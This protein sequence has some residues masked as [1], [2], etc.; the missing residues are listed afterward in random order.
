MAVINYS[1][2]SDSRTAAVCSKI[3]NEREGQSLIVASNMNRARRLAS[4]L[5]FFVKKKIYLLESEDE[6]L[7]FYE[8]KNREPLQQR[9]NAMK[10]LSTGEDCV[11]VA[12]VFSAVKKLM[13]K[14]EFIKNS[15]TLE[16]NSEMDIKE[17]ATKLVA[18]GYERVSLV[19]GKGQFSIRGSILDIYLPYEENPTR[20]EFFDIE[21]ESIRVFD[22]DTQRSLGKLSKIHIYPAVA[23]AIEDEHIKKAVAQVE[24][25]YEH[26]PQRLGELVEQIEQK[27]N[28]QHLEYYIDYFFEKTETI[29][30]YLDQQVV[31]IDDPTRCMEAIE[32]RKAEYD[33]D[34][35]ELLNRG[36]VS[37]FDYGNFPGPEEYKELYKKE[38]VILC[39]PFS[40]KIDGVEKYDDLKEMKILEPLDFNGQMDVLVRE[41]RKYLQREYK[42]VIAVSTE[43]RYESLK[44]L[45][46][47][48]KITKGITLHRGTLSRGM[49][50]V[51]QQILLLSDKDIFGTQKKTKR[52][53]RKFKNAK[54]IKTFS[55]IKPG[56][57]VVHEAHGVGKYI[58]IKQMEIQGIKK[59]Y[60]HVKY[61][62]DD[63]LYVPVEQMDLIQKYVGS[64]SK[65][66]KI[67]KLSGTEWKKTKAKAKEAIA[68]MAQELIEL[69]ATR[70]AEAGYQFAPDTPWQREFENDFQYVETDDQLRCIEEIKM[71]MEKP[72]AM[73]RLLCGDVGYG[74]TE[75]AAR[76][77]FKCASEGKQVAVLVPTT[78]L[79]SQHY[80]TLKSR[81]EKF[82]FKVE[83]LSRFRTPAQQKLIKEGV[84]QGRID[85][86]VGTHALLSDDVMFKD[87]GLL[88]ID[89][90]QRFGVSD[91]EKIKKLR[92]N[93]DVLTLSATPIPRTLHMSLVGIRNMSVIEEPPQE[94]IPVQTYVMEEDD[95]V[96]REAIERE[97]ARG[98]QVFI[99]YNK[100]RGI[101]K[102]ANR[103]QSLV[104]DK[105]ILV[106]HG[107]MSQHQLE[108]VMLQFVDGQAD[109]LIATTIIETGIDIPNANTEIIIDAD[110]YGLSQLYQL[111]GRVGRSTKLAYAY[112]MHKKEKTLNEV[113]EKRLR[114]IKEFTE[115][116][117]G[118]K[119]AMRDLEI[120]G[121]GNLLG[122]AQSG[123]MVSIGYEL[124]C[125]LVDEAVAALKGEII[126]EDVEKDDVVIGI[127]VPAFIPPKYIADEVTKLN[128]Y[129]QIAQV[130]NQM[131]K[132]DLIEEL[133]DR[134]GNLPDE[135]RNLI[136]ASLIKTY[137]NELCIKKVVERGEQI[138][139]DYGKGGPKPIAIYKRSGIPVLEDVADFLNLMS[140]KQKN[141]EM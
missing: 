14:A 32:T 55:E 86:I 79:A 87:L 2:I 58:G 107:Q 84:R 13:P 20:I 123:H 39:T 90:E 129:K 138:I 18:M 116:G 35:R 119:I 88:V 52:K 112:L 140:Q 53:V 75:V 127:K 47:R 64:E 125:K 30:D 11:V 6:T 76:A 114:A 81:F 139:F 82:P 74:K 62:G 128:V 38:D 31:F 77:M 16:L 28:I 117:A 12:P 10:A 100:V 56:D 3:I 15:M 8:A 126:K 45:F 44:D 17:I 111:R 27:S 136:C 34:F 135:V 57:Y 120:R 63:V 104:P 69:S 118:F 124:Y 46:E 61:A 103:I 22:V 65:T 68:E 141:V 91:K 43:D 54:P 40:R 73:D 93:I 94:R 80:N 121:A 106:G 134:F 133:E 41:I 25:R 102:L 49:E 9:L 92:K 5:S 48:E 130:S 70:K 42:V 137:A 96:I 4:D 33:I 99:V 115:F 66:P 23:I 71:D 101:Q 109:V 50:F 85:V 122:T 110:K 108:D 29:V 24:R 67:Y 60:L 132:E 83:M 7:T 59:D 26:M 19:Y 37:R 97:V 21:V 51:H 36:M 72:E 78:I 1:G 95:F 105:R 89:E 131:E 113:A 98:G